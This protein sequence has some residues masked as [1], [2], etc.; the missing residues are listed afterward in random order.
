MNQVLGLTSRFNILGLALVVL[1]AAATTSRADD[2]QAQIEIDLGEI[3]IQAVEQLE[4]AADEAEGE[5][6]D[7]AGPKD[8]VIEIDGFGGIELPD[9]FKEM[10][11]SAQEMQ[12]IKAKYDAAVAKLIEEAKKLEDPDSVMTAAA[13][14][15]ALAK[16]ADEL[17]QEMD[18]KQKEMM[19]KMG[20]GIGVFGG[21]EGGAIE[22]K[23]FGGGGIDVLPVFPKGGF[24]IPDF[25]PKAEEGDA[26]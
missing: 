21:A 20:G 4:V 6:E 10:M 19:K 2:Q 16:E 3:V 11:K 1:L 13:K 8:G 25:G 9:N 23:G 22:L 17:K 15:A 14:V 12:A 24:P 5:A 18:T 7:P 26:P